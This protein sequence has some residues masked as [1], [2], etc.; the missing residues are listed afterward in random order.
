MKMKNRRIMLVV[1]A[2]TV[3]FG[4]GSANSADFSAD[5][6]TETQNF[7]TRTIEA[8]INN[9]ARNVGSG[10]TIFSDMQNRMMSMVSSAIKQDTAARKRATVIET[11]MECRVMQ[12]IKFDV[13]SQTALFD[14]ETQERINRAMAK[15]I[16]ETIRVISSD[17][18]VALSV[19][20][21]M[22]KE[23]MATNPLRQNMQPFMMS[24]L[25][26]DPSVIN[27]AGSK[28][29]SAEKQPDKIT[30]SAGDAGFPT[31]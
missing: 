13:T 4:S 19:Q 3:I 20:E 23:R 25:F 7:V 6:G 21:M 24:R 11:C 18:A 17:P 15:R 27:V 12:P 29:E 14:A 9:A 10:Q 1:A 8:N 22:M 26:S 5:F 31:C 28:N 16:E 30:C 2:L